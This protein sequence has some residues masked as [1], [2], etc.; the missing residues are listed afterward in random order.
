MIQ[1]LEDYISE[2]KLVNEKWNA[3]KHLFFRGHSNLKEFKLKPSILRNSKFKEKEVLLD[4]KQYAPAHKIN[5]NFI[6]ERDRML[7]D[8]QHYGIP[9]RLLDWTIAPLNALFFA[10]CENFEDDGEVIVFNPWKYWGIIVRDKKQEEI[11]QIHITSRALLSG[12]WSFDKI[13]NFIKTNYDYDNLTVEDITKPFAFVANYTN[14]RIIH[15]RG[16]FTIHGIDTSELDTVKEA[17]DCVQRI[18]IK[19]SIKLDLLNELNQLYINEY[20]IFPD[21]EG[22][23]EMVKNHGSLFNLKNIKS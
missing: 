16:C 7:A 8:M 23:K 4:F 21:F 12:G 9:T 14:D 1:K 15:Q 17:I 6:H 18:E 2:I 13:N 22:M 5:Y 20:S 19:A 3:K 10:C 11:H